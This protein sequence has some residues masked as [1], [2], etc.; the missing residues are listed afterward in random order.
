[1]FL[2]FLYT[3]IADVN[4]TFVITYPTNVL[5]VCITKLTE[6]NRGLQ[7]LSIYSYVLV[8]LSYFVII[9]SVPQELIYESPERTKSHTSNIT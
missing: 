5:Y 7:S 6:R 2:Q 8:L 9:S 4:C 1:M 3:F